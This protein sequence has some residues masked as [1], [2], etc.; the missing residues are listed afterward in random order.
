MSNCEYTYT[1]IM[2]SLNYKG[3]RLYFKLR[4]YI[5]Y[6]EITSPSRKGFPQI[7]SE[8]QLW[9][10]KNCTLI[11]LLPSAVICLFTYK[12]TSISQHTVTLIMLSTANSE[13]LSY[14]LSLPNQSVWALSFQVTFLANHIHS[15]QQLPD[16]T[17]H[18]T[19][20]MSMHHLY[21]NPK[22]P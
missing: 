17:Q 4:P 12:P 6:S 18:R 22:V 10:L 7:S 13:I 16:E 9:F 8:H 20:P 19:H 11:Q 1:V 5:Y 14:L 2:F 21:Q 3:N 15:S